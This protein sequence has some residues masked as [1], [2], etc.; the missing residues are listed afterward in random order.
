MTSA[1]PCDES[2]ASTLAGFEPTFEIS[3]YCAIPSQTYASLRA[4]MENENQAVCTNRAELRS[5]ECP[6]LSEKQ[7][8][9]FTALVLVS[10]LD[11]SEP[12]RIV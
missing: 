2:A 6:N 11:A 3:R 1:R 7:L 9:G 4:T 12:A 10:P 8:A 5:F